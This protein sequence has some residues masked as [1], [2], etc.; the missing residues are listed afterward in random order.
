[1]LAGKGNMSDSDFLYKYSDQYRAKSGEVDAQLARVSDEELKSAARRDLWSK[2][3]MTPYRA[4]AAKNFAAARKAFFE[5]HKDDFFALGRFSGFDPES[6]ELEVGPGD[7]SFLTTDLTVS[8]D[9]L[10]MDTILSKFRSIHGGEI[11]ARV[12]QF[13][14]HSSELVQETKR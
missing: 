10:Q 13:M 1:M 2:I 6:K 14:A 11:S 7:L 4:E 3:N 5:G 12:E 8:V 9:I